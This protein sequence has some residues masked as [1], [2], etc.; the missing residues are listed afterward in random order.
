VILVGG[1]I[2]LLGGTE[3]WTHAPGRARGVGDGG[4]SRW[5]ASIVGCA[6]VWTAAGPCCRPLRSPWW[7]SG[8]VRDGGPAGGAVL[9]R[10][11]RW[12]TR[13]HAIG[14]SHAPPPGRCRSRDALERRSGGSG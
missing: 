9:S 2:A 10:T 7:R 1:L 12:A 11:G 13:V 3:G 6:M 8:G 5:R 4:R 14:I